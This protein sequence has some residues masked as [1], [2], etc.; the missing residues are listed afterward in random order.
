MTITKT[1][2][3]AETADLWRPV[4]K[5]GFI[6]KG[7]IPWSKNF[8]YQC[9]CCSY[10]AMFMPKGDAEEKGMKREA[11]AKHCPMWEAWGG[12]GSVSC[13]HSSSIYSKWGRQYFNTAYDRQFFATLITEWAEYLWE[14]EYE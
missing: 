3:L 8:I 2:A 10:V 5:K 11:C 13:E 14:K 4:A 1:E 12:H 9:P 7:L 6:S